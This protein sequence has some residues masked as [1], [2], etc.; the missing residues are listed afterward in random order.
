MELPELSGGIPGRG[1]SQRSAGNPRG[2]VVGD[3][4]GYRHLFAILPFPGTP[5]TDIRIDLFAVEAVAFDGAAGCDIAHF[6]PGEPNFLRFPLKRQTEETQVQ[7]R[8][9]TAFQNGEAERE[10]TPLRSDRGDLLRCFADIDHPGGNGNAVFP[11]HRKTLTA[12]HLEFGAAAEQRRE[13]KN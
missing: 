1:N 13:E 10:I 12:I 2:R 11:N 3:R 5:E 6:N 9:V 8:I 4:G 7:R